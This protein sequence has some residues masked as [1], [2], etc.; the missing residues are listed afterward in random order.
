MKQ[1]K[2]IKKSICSWCGIQVAKG[3]NICSSCYQ[4]GVHKFNLFVDRHEL[5]QLYI[6]F[7]TPGRVSNTVNKNQG[8]YISAWFDGANVYIHLVLVIGHA[9]V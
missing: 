1:P 4:A 3:A 9:L 6:N 5:C 7:E 2:K 8:N